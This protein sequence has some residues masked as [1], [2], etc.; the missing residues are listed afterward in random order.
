MNILDKNDGDE[1]LER[2]WNQMSPEEQESHRILA[3]SLAPH[4]LIEYMLNKTRAAPDEMLPTP[5][6]DQMPSMADWDK[7]EKI[8]EQR[9]KKLLNDEWK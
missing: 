9:T 3:E 2:I 8:T 5:S 1:E 6:A 4:E 7:A